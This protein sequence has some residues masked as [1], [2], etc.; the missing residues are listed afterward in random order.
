M[1]AFCTIRCV[2]GRSS[3]LSTSLQESETQEWFA[4]NMGMFFG[5]YHDHQ[6]CHGSVKPQQFPKIQSLHLKFY[7]QLRSQLCFS[8]FQCDLAPTPMK[9]WMLFCVI[10]V[11]CFGHFLR[12]QESRKYSLMRTTMAAKT[13]SYIHYRIIYIIIF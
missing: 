3:L 4:P 11:V 7:L 1:G 13:L 2:R 5:Y 8:Y 10:Y 9:T 6:K 12:P